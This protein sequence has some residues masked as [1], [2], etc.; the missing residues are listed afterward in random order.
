MIDTDYRFGF[1]GPEADPNAV[2]GNPGFEKEVAI[3]NNTGTSGGVR[4][5][6]A[7]GTANPSIVNFQA[8]IS[9]HYQVSYAL[10]QQAGCSDKPV[11]VDMFVPFSALGISS[12][13]QVRIAVAVNEDIDSSLGGGAS[14]IG[15][16]DGNALPDD[17]DQFIAAI[18]NFSPIAVNDPVNKAPTVSN[19]S[20]IVNE[21]SSVGTIVSAVPADDINGDAL[22]WSIEAGNT[23]N[24]FS[25][26]P[27]TGVIQ[28][29][30][31]ALLDFEMSPAFVL[32]VRVSDGKLYDNAII[33]VQL[34]DV[35]EP[36]V[37]MDAVVSIAENSPVGT[38][39]HTMVGGDPDVN[40]V[41]VYS[42]AGGNSA[43]RF[44]INSSTG[45][46][47]VSDNE[48]LDFET[49]ASHYLEVHVTDGFFTDKSFVTI[50]VTDVN[51]PPV[52]SDATTTLDENTTAGVVVA[53]VD[54]S[55]Q[56]TGSVLQF[57]I[58]QGNTGGAFAIDNAD[59]SI[60]VNNAS[61]LDFETNPVFNLIITV[62]DGS[63][64]SDADIV[65]NLGNINEPPV[66]QDASVVV[67][68]KLKNND[69]LHKVVARDPDAG[70]I[71]TFSLNDFG[72]PVP[73]ALDALSGEISILDAALTT[74][75]LFFEVVVVVTDQSGLT[76]SARIGITII[77]QPDWSEVLPQKGFSPN[78]D[79]QN[80]FW[81]IRGIAA[82]P[83][84]NIKV[85]NRW[86]LLVCELNG[87]DNERRVWQG[88]V[89][90][91]H[92]RTESTYFYI[93]T[94]PDFEPI[95]GYIIVSP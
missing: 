8:P 13:L 24:T 93:I 31:A 37:F 79:S 66:V 9:T 91:Q 47:L 85:F 36:P 80:D 16:V 44:T 82:F 45:E 89:N 83:D 87:Y 74:P 6:N 57:S 21:N 65:I 62:S 11:F 4:V 19:A 67:E 55:D 32:V 35:N 81:M 40:A 72:H 50:Q 34:N 18:N 12:A 56:D 68:A 58:T 84:N 70:D 76:A 60:T 22:T 1:T 86:G 53:Q 95:T 54:A 92:E 33:T 61:L 15:G 51:E 30:N 59:G 90:G 25:I 23:G 7:D 10:N 77:R 26:D 64:F 5:W 39:V 71:I 49:S 75:S 52:V 78:G 73:I 42:I 20:V 48:S 46:I 43:N 17:D 69:I 27:A 3:F 2:A 41:L 63:L 94:A 88:E 14:D 29:N 38:L 28:I